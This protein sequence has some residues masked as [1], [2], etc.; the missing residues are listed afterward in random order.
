MFS[1]CSV[2]RFLF[3]SLPLR[4]KEN[5]LFLFV[6]LCFYFFT[7]GL[8]FFLF[9]TE[10]TDPQLFHVPMFDLV[11]EYVQHTTSRSTYVMLHAGTEYESYLRCSV[12]WVQLS[13]LKSQTFPLSV[14][15]D[16]QQ[17]SIRTRA[18]GD[19]G[20]ALLGSQ[21]KGDKSHQW[22]HEW[23]SLLRYTLYFVLCTLHFAL[24][25]MLYF[26]WKSQNWSFIALEHQIMRMSSSRTPSWMKGGKF[27][28]RVQL[29]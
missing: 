16:L 6:F 26:V 5:S 24:C 15:L 21:I 27:I 25:T 28:P 12:Y 10:S 20:S 19:T 29:G 23:W 4:S 2:C 18:V 14:D 1:F 9:L 3:F 13:A 7:W 17:Y 11:M 8:G 22:R